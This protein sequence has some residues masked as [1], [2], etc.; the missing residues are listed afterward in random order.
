MSQRHKKKK[1][2]TMRSSSL[3][4]SLLISRLTDIIIEIPELRRAFSGKMIY[5]NKPFLEMDVIKTRT[6]HAWIKYHQH[7]II[8][9]GRHA[10]HS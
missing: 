2:F 8:K 10:R 5:V 7:G 3:R 6:L 4:I 9:A 1:G